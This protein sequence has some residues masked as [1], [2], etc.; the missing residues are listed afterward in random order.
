MEMEE[1]F[2]N[3]IKINNCYNINY[4]NKNYLVNFRNHKILLQDNAL[5]EKIENKD[6]STLEWL[7][8]EEMFDEEQ[9]TIK[10]SEYEPTM[11]TFLMTTECNLNC[12]YCYAYNN[13]SK[14]LQFSHAKLCIDYIVNNAVKKGK[15]GITVKFHGAGEP[16]LNME[17]IVKIVE[18]TKKVA[19]AHH[20]GVKFH[21]TTN[22]VMNDEKR[23]WLAENMDVITVSFDGFEKQQNI[24]R[25]HR[26][27]NSFEEVIKSLEIFKNK[28]VNYGIRTTVTD[29]NIDILEEWAA[30][31]A[32]VCVKNLNVEPVSICGNCFESD[33][34]DVD[35]LTFFKKYIQLQE[36]GKR[37]GIN[38]S[39]SGVKLDKT[40]YIHCGGYGSNFVVTPDNSIST[41][42]E[43]FDKENIESDCFIIGEVDNGKVNINVER[44]EQLRNK[45]LNN[46]TKCNQCF[47]EYQC[48]GGC[49]SRG[50]SDNEFICKSVQAKCKITKLILLHELQNVIENNNLID[51]EIFEF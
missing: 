6:L 47:A 32:K 19:F 9:K 16:T 44:V 51:N 5:Y 29:N 17:V 36:S 41:C 35:C 7:I 4:K 45:T 39:Y 1:I 49:I 25:P 26:M 15:K 24:Q 10:L 12:I 33:V 38:V 21:I 48:G 50:L 31:L 37:N 40:I 18:Y 3:I 20:I 46:R 8:Y 23:L 11:V 28:G 27:L 43:V 2:K 14:K 13:I 34:K 30:F 42:Y 22:G